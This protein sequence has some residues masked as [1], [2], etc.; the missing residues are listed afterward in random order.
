MINK[1]GQT[2]IEFLI[3]T[4]TF[5]LAISFI[6]ITASGNL[7]EEVQK[8]QMQD[9]CLKTYQLEALLR[10]PGSP[11][12]WDYS[13]GFTVFGL[14][15]DSNKSIIVSN[16]KWGAAKNFT[17]VNVSAN[18]T[19]SQSWRIS[20]TAKYSN[21]TTITDSFGASPPPNALMCTTK[22]NGVLNAT[23]DLLLTSFNLEAW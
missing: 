7:K 18:S 5:L 19:P 13:S 21:G 4:S 2:W 9:A 23:P 16:T 11:A 20:Y 3:V 14:N 15:Q 22:V 17:F 12:N 1:K 10:S 6:F 8:S